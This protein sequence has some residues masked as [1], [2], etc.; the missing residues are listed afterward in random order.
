MGIAFALFILV[1]LAVGLFNRR[2]ERRDWVR[3]E[4]HDESGAWMDKR[5][6]ERGTYGSLD[7]ERETERRLV[8]R[9]GQAGELARRVREY[10]F[11]QYPD[12]HALSDARIR[13]FLDFLKGEAGE[14]VA[15]LGDFAAGRLPGEVELPAA[16]PAPLPAL[17]RNMLDFAYER[18]PALLDL[19]IDVLKLLDRHTE[20][21]AA[22]LIARIEALKS[23][24]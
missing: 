19:D 16:K 20:V 10:C 14:Y 22:G 23:G 12:F 2:R 3:E 1:V 9:Q 17:K 8:A 13:I 6:G 21:L 24:E 7:D 15:L 4:R 18:Y 11:E 5:A